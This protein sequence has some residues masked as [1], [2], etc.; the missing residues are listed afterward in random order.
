LNN[1]AQG[2][3][4]AALGNRCKE[5]PTLKGLHK[6]LDLLWNPFRVLDLFGF[7]PRAALRFAL[8]CVV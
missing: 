5:N 1:K 2:K 6:G 3:R 7:F 8:G 4:S